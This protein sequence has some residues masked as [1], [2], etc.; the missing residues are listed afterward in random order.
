MPI[1]ETIRNT[2][3]E[4]VLLLRRRAGWSQPELAARAGMSVTAVNRVEN[5]H[6]SLYVEKLA[7]LAHALDTTPDFLLG[8]SDEVQAPARRD[9][10]QEA[11]IPAP[12]KRPRPRKAASVA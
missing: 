2:L 8:F 10:R 6:Q 1:D 5:A 9:T 12:A 3:A 4:R 7:H 11:A